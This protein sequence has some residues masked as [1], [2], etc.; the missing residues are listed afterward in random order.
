MIGLSVFLIGIWLA[1]Q[2][3]G[4]VATNDWRPLEFAAFGVAAFWVAITILRSWRTG[5]YMFMVWLL[6]E[7]LVRK[8][9][10]NNMAIYFGKDVLV[11][12]VYI[13]FFAQVRRGGKKSFVRRSCFR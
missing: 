12:L 4:K 5:F 8:Y 9:L 2:V 7:D 1:W 6:F 10:G 11:G 3:G 13:S